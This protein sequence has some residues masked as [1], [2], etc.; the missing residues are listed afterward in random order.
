MIAPADP[1][2]AAPTPGRGARSGL[3]IGLK[4][5]WPFDGTQFPRLPWGGEAVAP[6][7]VELV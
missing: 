2:A 5:E 6:A 4:G 7:D 3:V 1:A